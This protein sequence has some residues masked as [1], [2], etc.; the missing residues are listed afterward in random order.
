MGADDGAKSLSGGLGPVDG[1]G[2]ITRKG[3]AEAEDGDRRESGAVLL[4]DCVDEV[5]STD[6]D[7]RD[8]GGVNV[9]L[10]E[11]SREDGMDPYGRIGSGGGLVP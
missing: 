7:A 11:E 6:C 9:G 3:P 5:S 2:Y 10:G 8:A 1:R 4:N